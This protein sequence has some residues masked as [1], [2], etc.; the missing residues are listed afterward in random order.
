MEFGLSEEEQ[1]LQGEVRDFLKRELKE[2]SRREL[3]W[4]LE[5]SPGT[6]DFLRKLGERRW[7]CPTWSREYGGLALSNMSRYIIVEELH[8]YTAPLPFILIGASTVGPTIMLHGIEE[9]KREYLPRIARGEIEFSLGY[10]EP[11]A[12]SDIASLDI[13]AVEDGD[14][15]VMNGQKVFSGRAHFAQYHWLAAR[16]DPQA[17]KHRGISLFIVDLKS[18]GITTRPIWMMSGYRTNEVFYDDVRVPKKN[19]VGEKNRGFYIM[20]SALDFERMFAVSGHERTLELLV[21]YARET[22]HN[23]QP[24]AKNPQLRHKLSE[25]DIEVAVAR[26]LAYRV[27]WMQDRRI[28]P[29]YESAM[30]KVFTSE[31]THRLAGAGMQLLGLYGQLVEGSKWA[32]LLGMIDQLYREAI[33]YTI[34]GGTSE[35]QRNVIAIRGLGLPRQN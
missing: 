1:R 27:V 24:L 9:Q 19:M 25:L 4:G 15:Y 13:R 32:Q 3:N 7:I 20:A 8:Y 29:S 34:A 35:I 22:K 18:P 21:E 28:V 31:L 6:W 17:P 16:T 11:E 5:F 10:T 12:G 30:L 14:D 23:G 33:H 2:E 26:V